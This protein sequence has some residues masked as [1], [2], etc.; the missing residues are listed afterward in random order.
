LEDKPGQPI[1]HAPGGFVKQALKIATILIIL[2]LF[3]AFACIIWLEKTLFQSSLFI[4]ISIIFMFLL[5]A[6]KYRA[7]LKLMLPFV[8]I[9]FIV[10]MVFGLVGFRATSIHSKVFTIMDYWF[11]FALSR[12]FLLL[13]TVLLI[14]LL[15]SF[16]TLQDVMKLPIG[17]QRQ[18]V[19]ILART[20]Y[21]HAL[22]VLDDFEFH[23]DGIPT[24]QVTGRSL[25]QY[26]HKK[27]ALILALLFMVIKESQIGGELI[28]NRIRHCFKEVKE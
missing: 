25:K 21:I 5:G 16:F 1:I 28:D 19:I 14:Q 3:I 8:S 6:E 11:L 27:L 7:E 10:Y 24:N 2:A 18:K 13:S 12:I 22:G 9:L 23:I 15:I 20:L 17:I 26:V 4:L